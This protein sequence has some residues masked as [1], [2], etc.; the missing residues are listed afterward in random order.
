MIGTG[1]IL[2]FHAAKK[3]P[4]KSTM[5]REIV[6]TC[7]CTRS[8]T[9]ENIIPATA[10]AVP[11]IA[12]MTSAFVRHDSYPTV[13]RTASAA[14]GSVTASTAASAP[15]TPRILPPTAAQNASTLVPGVIRASA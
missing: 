10:A 14:D 12:A 5:T 3:A 11:A 13:N 4:P 9:V 1:E 8:H 6:L 7:G 2:N 15:G